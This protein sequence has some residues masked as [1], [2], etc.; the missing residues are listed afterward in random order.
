MQ[1]G[2]D[3][4][5]KMINLMGT[6]PLISFF[7]QDYPFLDDVHEEFGEHFDD[8]LM[9]NLNDDGIP[10]YLAARSAKPPTACLT[11]GHTIKG[12]YTPSGK[13]KTATTI[14]AKMD[15]RAGK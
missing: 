2:T 12:G 6:K 10:I 8:D 14:P 3:N 11:P 1:T 13:Y 7:L 5:G 9:M 15:K 4:S